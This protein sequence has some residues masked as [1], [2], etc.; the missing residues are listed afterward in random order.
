[1]NPTRP[2]ILCV[3]DEPLMLEGLEAG[4]RRRYD[5][6]TA[7]DG[8]QGLNTLRSESSIAVVVSDMRMPVMDGAAFLAEARQAAPD[9]VRLLL[10]GQADI[11]AAIAAVNEGQVFRFL[12]KPCPPAQLL[13]AVQCAV[14]QHDLLTAERILLERTLRGSIKALMDV[15][16]LSNPKA[17]G[18][19]TRIKQ[20]VQ[21]LA[22]RMDIAERWPLEVA[23][24]LSQIGYVALPQEIVEK[25]YGGQDLNAAEQEKV[26]LLPDIAD[27]LLEDIPRLEPVRGIIRA[28]ARPRARSAVLKADDI[29]GLGT[30]ILRIA[31]DFDHLEAGG[32]AESMALS[33]MKSRDGVYDPVLLDIFLSLRAANAKLLEVRELRLSAIRVGMVLAEDVRMKNGALLAAQG[34]EVTHGFVERVRGFGPDMVKEP[35]RVIISSSKGEDPGQPFKR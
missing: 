30:E 19:A 18:R 22:I 6:F 11:A 20:H 24:M 1:V 25:L 35:V 7:L 5:V 28:H 27:Q 23:A 32:A 17:F 4:L 29:V 16:S 15:L 21:D 13:T 26:A 34:Y 33:T 8:K 10:T 14:E 2:K 9:A 31:V 12:T 3:D